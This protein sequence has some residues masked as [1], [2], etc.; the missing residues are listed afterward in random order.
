MKT[1][2]RLGFGLAFIGLGFGWYFLIRGAQNIGD[3]WTSFAVCGVG[4]LL[5]FIADW[6]ERISN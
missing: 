6:R 3:I 2:I 4:V 5:I 1:L